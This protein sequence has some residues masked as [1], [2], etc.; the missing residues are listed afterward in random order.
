MNDRQLR[1]E[2][3]AWAKTRPGLSKDALHDAWRGYQAAAAPR[4]EL[5]GKLVDALASVYCD[6]YDTKPLDEGVCKEV[7]QALADAK[8]KG[9]GE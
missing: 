6:M 5:I 1:E 8:A 7:K 3:E 4:D 2:F 9:Y